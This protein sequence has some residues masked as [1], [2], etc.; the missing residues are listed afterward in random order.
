VYPSRPGS[1]QPE[2]V[3]T[4]ENVKNGFV[5]KSFVTVG[6]SPYLLR[7]LT[8]QAESFSMHGPIHQYLLNG[9][10]EMI[11]RMGQSVIEKRDESMPQLVSVLLALQTGLQLTPS[12]S[13]HSAS[14]PA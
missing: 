9:G 14:L 7:G 5:A 11:M 6:V 13:G 8:T 2:D 4:E 3:L 10:L 12:A 1:N